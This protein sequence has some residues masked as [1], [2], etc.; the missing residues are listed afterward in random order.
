MP[1]TQNTGGKDRRRYGHALLRFFVTPAVSAAGS[2][3]ATV[4]GVCATICVPVR[5]S[6]TCRPRRSK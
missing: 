3:R 2:L 4:H 5:K 1:G 6:C